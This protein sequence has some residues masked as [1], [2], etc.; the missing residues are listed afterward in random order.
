[1]KSHVTVIPRTNLDPRDT[2][3]SDCTM[4]YRRHLILFSCPHN[5]GICGQNGFLGFVREC[6][7]IQI[8]VNNLKACFEQVSHKC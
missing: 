2:S 7:G 1:M 5:G 8:V 6:N 4:D 3:V